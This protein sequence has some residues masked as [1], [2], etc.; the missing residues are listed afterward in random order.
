MLDAPGPRDWTAARAC[1]KRESKITKFQEFHL[2][3][4]G[5]NDRKVSNSKLDFSN[6]TITIRV[7]TQPHSVASGN[8]FVHLSTPS[9]TCATNHSLDRARARRAQGLWRCPHQRR[10]RSSWRGASGFNGPSETFRT[11][12]GFKCFKMSRGSNLDPIWFVL[13]S[14][15]LPF[16]QSLH[17]R[18]LLCLSDHQSGD[19]PAQSGPIN[20]ILSAKLS[21]P[22]M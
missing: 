7:V 3:C 21:T 10:F 19:M 1:A 8:S 13:A 20:R 6:P 15:G 12:F 2:S 14:L 4:K 16:F 17:A 5:E 11:V 22:W 18:G 9:P